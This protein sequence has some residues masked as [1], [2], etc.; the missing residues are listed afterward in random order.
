MDVYKILKALAASD[1]SS[2]SETWRRVEVAGSYPLVDKYGNETVSE[3]VR[4]WFERSDVDRVNWENFLW[5]DTY[6]IAM[7]GS[8]WFHPA[9]QDGDAMGKVILEPKKTVPENVRPRLTG[10][11]TLTISIVRLPGHR[12]RVRGSTNLPPDTALLITVTKK[13]ESSGPQSKCSVSADGQFESETLM[14]QKGF[15]PGTYLAEVVMPIPAVQPRQVQEVIGRNGEHLS[16]PLVEKGTLGVTVRATKEFTVG[17][18]IEA[19]QK[20]L[21]DL[22][23][24]LAKHKAD[25]KRVGD[26]ADAKAKIA[27][28]N[29]LRESSAAIDKKLREQE[30][31]LIRAGEVSDAEVKAYKAKLADLQRRVREAKVLLVKAQRGP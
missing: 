16:G 30:E 15:R 10:P 18:D 13:A 26:Y 27:M 20:R 25:N 17:G 4:M 19:A 28:Y 6:G 5:D 22:A 21:D 8:S 31:R 7:D 1:L 2:A 12:L 24:L 29:G 9:F 11:V 23:A 3:V 14:P